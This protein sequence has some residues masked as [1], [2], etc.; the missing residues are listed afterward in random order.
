MDYTGRIFQRDV[1]RTSNETGLVPQK[2][3]GDKLSHISAFLAPIYGFEFWRQ[4]TIK[5][6]VKLR[7]NAYYP[8]V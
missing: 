8:T 5:V 3:N 1:Q 2:C 4:S 7:L 6:I